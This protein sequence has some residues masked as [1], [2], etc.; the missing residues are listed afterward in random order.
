MLK[1]KTVQI[2]A[3]RRVKNRVQNP[4]VKRDRLDATHKDLRL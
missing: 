1:I 3:A 4:P 2:K